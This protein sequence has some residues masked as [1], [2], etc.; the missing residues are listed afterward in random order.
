M[1]GKGPDT[2]R[3]FENC[4]WDI[5]RYI[6]CS[7]AIYWHSNIA[8]ESSHRTEFQ[9]IAKLHDFCNVLLDFW[10]MYEESIAKNCKELQRIAKHHLRTRTRLLSGYAGYLLGSAVLNGLAG[11][12]TTAG[13]WE[14]GEKAMPNH[15]KLW[16]ECGSKAECCQSESKKVL[17][18]FSCFV[19][20]SKECAYVKQLGS[21]SFANNILKRLSFDGNQ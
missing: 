20:T 7:A 13:V 8:L 5:P 3:T 11:N 21:S 2:C 6:L 1:R 9:S 10:E 16:A 19:T 17:R 14:E 18:I 4:C 12:R 15:V